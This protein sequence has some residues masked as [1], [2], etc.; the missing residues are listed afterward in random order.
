MTIAHNSATPVPFL[1][2]A[3]PWLICGIAMLFYCFNYFL[4]VSPSV[5]QNELSQAFHIT[6]TQFGGL[7]AFYYYAYTPMQLPAGMLYDKFGV[8]FVLCFACFLAAVGLAIFISADNYTNYRSRHDVR[9]I[10]T[11]ISDQCN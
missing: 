3:Y 4:R 6:A 11:K 9:R 2:S 7:A 1:K 5:M 10:S 8:R